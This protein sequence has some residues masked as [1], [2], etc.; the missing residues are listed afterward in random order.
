MYEIIHP[1][2]LFIWLIDELG[3]DREDILLVWI[4]GNCGS[5]GAN[6]IPKLLWN[7]YVRNNSLGFEVRVK[8]QHDENCED[9]DG[10]WAKEE[11][12]DPF[13]LLEIFLHTDW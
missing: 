10:N 12:W 6:D 11:I 7:K 9:E 3:K 2:I 1:L 13:K 8:G 5:K 4:G